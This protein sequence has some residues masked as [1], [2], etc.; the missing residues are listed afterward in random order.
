[1]KKEKNSSQE[2]SKNLEL[3][4][5]LNMEIEFPKDFEKNQKA[6]FDKLKDP[7]ISFSKHL[8]F[9]KQQYRNQALLNQGLTAKYKPVLNPA[10]TECGNGDFQ[11]KIDLSEWQGA[12]GDVRNIPGSFTDGFISGAINNGNSH[13]TWVGPGTDPNAPIQTIAPSS[14]GAVR[15][16]N[17]VNGYGAELIS[18]TFI[19]SKST[20][21]FW[22]AT[23]MQNP[24][25][26]PPSDQPL[27]WVR[28]TDAGG[29][30][31]P[32]AFD[33]GNGSDKLI[34]DKNNPFFK[35]I[36]D[37]V[38]KD[39]SCAQIDLSSHIG[40]Q[41]TIEFIA[42]D[43]GYGGH[44]G[45]AYIGRYCDT[46]KGSPTGTIN[47]DCDNSHQC[48][49]GTLCF[50][51]T[52]PHTVDAQGNTIT[53]TVDIKL[54]IIQNGI[55]IASLSSPTLSSGNNYCFAIDPSTISGLNLGLGG[56]DFMVNAKF[57]IGSTVV[58]TKKIGNPQSGVAKG[59]NND[60]MVTCKTCDDYKNEIEAEL[61]R[62]CKGKA[63]KLEPY[64]CK[65][66]DNDAESDCGCSG[67]PQDEQVP[68]DCCE[69]AKLPKLE[70]CISLS[71]GDSACDC[72]ETT[73]F[74]VACITVCN[75]Y[76]NVSF[77][78]FRISKIVITDGNGNPVQNLPNGKP[79]IELVPSGAICFG[80]IPP[81]EK[82]N[83]SCI[84]RE[85]VIN[86]LGA[87]SGKYQIR[88]QGICY[89]IRLS[90]QT[91]ICFDITLCGD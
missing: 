63:N 15:I 67:K 1:M 27:F 24:I 21:S 45:Y 36:G 44:W 55:L 49:N 11:E 9:E 59:L 83:P 77:E 54:D 87:R 26:H 16:G 68:K 91:E 46:C 47:Y 48:G 79:S 88:L 19:A 20:I 57:M 18:K 71:W 75:K 66:P 3:D 14:V 40:R 5:L 22:Y 34:A 28:V 82:G 90:Q 13:Q 37:V 33:F 53:G 7:E 78:D 72:L 50:E 4:K 10:M 2:L 35:S 80:D 51:Y 30:I 65:C 61:L 84:S 62:K 76:E 41:V 64:V 74:E 86:T 12:Y 6:K 70:P 81:C 23:V 17:N 39:W 25:G 29:A 73:D 38:Y 31:I 85:L 60:Y 43:C 56:F 8:E 42:G 89:K 32:G 52:L 69:K 58:A